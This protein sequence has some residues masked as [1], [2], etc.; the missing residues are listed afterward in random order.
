MMETHG[1]TVSLFSPQKDKQGRGGVIRY[2]NTGF[3]AWRRSRRQD[4]E[5]QMQQFCA[6]P[7]KV[8]AEGPRSKFGAAMPIGQSVSFEVD[9]YWYMSFDCLQAQKGSG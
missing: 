9:Q 5:S 6:G 2:L 8:V 7:Y 3:D 4:A 1:D